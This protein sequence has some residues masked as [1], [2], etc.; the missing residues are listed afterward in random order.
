[1]RE[2][3]DQLRCCVLGIESK[4]GVFVSLALFLAALGAIGVRHDYG[5]SCHEA[6]VDAKKLVVEAKI[7]PSRI[8]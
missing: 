1:M 2:G 4:D 3:A 8:W 5:T 7:D 6:K